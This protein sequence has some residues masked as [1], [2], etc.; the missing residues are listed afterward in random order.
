MKK[1]G[2]LIK[3]YRSENNLS[4]REFA[5]LC[6]MSHSYIDKLEKGIDPRN[7]KPVEPTLDVI[8][9][10]AFAMNMT[11]VDILSFIGKLNNVDSKKSK[12]EDIIE[13]NKSI[14]KDLSKKD[15]KQI[16]KDLQDMMEN[17]KNQP[18]DGFA[19]FDGD[20][21]IDEDDLALLEDAFRTALRVVKKLNKETYNPKKNKG[22]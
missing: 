21:N 22:K 7:G 12:S 10:V 17:I 8:E 20:T 15:L 4:L 1:I 19:A 14:D 13:Y 6:G 5:S 9:K 18:D 16:E 2:D 3:V 11:L